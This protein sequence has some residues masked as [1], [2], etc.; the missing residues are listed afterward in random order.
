MTSGL[1]HLNSVQS[2]ITLTFGQYCWNLTGIVFFT[3]SQVIEIGI[4]PKIK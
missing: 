2:I 3:I 1:S 4:D